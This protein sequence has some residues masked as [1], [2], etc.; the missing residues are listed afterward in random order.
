M[1]V[2]AARRQA[3]STVVIVALLLIASGP[4]PLAALDLSNG[5]IKLTLSQGIGRFSVSCLTKT[6]EGIAVPLL[7]AQD[8]R[9]TMLAVVVGNKVYRVGES[10]EFAETVEKTATGGRFIWR[11]SFLQVTETFTFIAASGSSETTGVRIDIGLKNLSEQ[12]ITAGVR[13]L[14]DTYLGETSFVHFRT[15]TL[16]QVTHELSLA[17][18]DRPAFWVSPLVGDPEDFGLQVMTSGPDITVPDRI[19]FANWKRLSDA[20]WTYDISAVRNFSLLPYSVNDSAVSHY[21]DP[22]PVPKGTE[23]T[24]TLALGRYSR[25]GLSATPPTPAKVAAARD[26]TSSTQGASAAVQAAR[27]DLATVDRILGQI[28]AILTAGSAVSDAEL[29]QIESALK[30][31]GGRADSYVPSTGK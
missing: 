1:T 31:L 7:A 30:E 24:V 15:N 26:G 2:L 19:V 22:R 20:P 29:S 18:N 3:A 28:S 11:S 25:E 12:D 17:A 23:I 21:Y 10:S 14:F 4:A 6:K 8:P 27:T 9:T 16:S 13:C 5:R